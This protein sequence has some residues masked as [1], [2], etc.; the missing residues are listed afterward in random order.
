MKRWQVEV[1]AKNHQ[2]D[3]TYQE[4]VKMHGEDEI[5]PIPHKGDIIEMVVTDCKLDIKAEVVSE[6]RSVVYELAYK[7]VSVYTRVIQVKPL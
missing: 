1:L 7:R 6:V 5:V 3:F 2:T 4:I